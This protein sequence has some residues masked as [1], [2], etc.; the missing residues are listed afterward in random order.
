[1]T[2]KAEE[3]Q[4]PT[5]SEILFGGAEVH[6]TY[7]LEHEK[8]VEEETVKVRI[9]PLSQIPDLIK[10]IG[11]D[12]SK[13][14]A[15]YCDKPEGWADSLTLT[16][17]EAILERGFALNYPTLRRYQQRHKQSI[18]L[19]R[20]N[21]VFQELTNILNETIQQILASAQPSQM[22]PSLSE[23]PAQN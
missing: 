22:P 14:I 23:S 4:G 18:M 19:I 13:L 8:D 7:L 12:E 3:V 21:P 6:I 10:A 15:V 17:Q 9:L 16:S 1:M 20:E 2:E 11:N 5:E